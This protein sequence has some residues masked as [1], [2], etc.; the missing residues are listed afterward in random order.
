M[1]SAGTNSKVLIVDD[2]ADIRS[3]TRTVLERRGYEVLE[4]D[5]GIPAYELITRLSGGIQVLVTDIRMPGMD[6]IALAEKVSAAYPKIKILYIS[7][8]AS[9][10]PKRRRPGHRFLPKPF[11]AGELVKCVESLT[12]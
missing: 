1:G 6:G 5:D 8:F 4:A 3:F 12:G 7:G 9:E 11:V 2:E 10:P